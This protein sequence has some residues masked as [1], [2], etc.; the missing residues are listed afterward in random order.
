M[1]QVDEEDATKGDKDDEAED[2]QG[3]DEDDEAK[4]VDDDDD[5]DKDAAIGN[6]DDE[7]QVHNHDKDDAN[8]V[9]E[10]KVEEV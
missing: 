8:G 6:K 10:N 2:V 7:A 1:C 3:N 9:E 5:D 4:D